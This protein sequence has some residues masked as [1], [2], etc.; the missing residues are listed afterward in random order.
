[1]PIQFRATFSVRSRSVTQLTTKRRGV[2]LLA[3][4]AFLAGAVFYLSDTA[5]LAAYAFTGFSWIRTE[6]IVTSPRTTSDP[7]IQFIARDQSP[8]LFREDYY[9]LCRRSLCWVR[10]FNPNQVVPVVYDPARPKR[11]YVGDW[12]LISGAITWF[13]MA[14]CVIFLGLMMCFAF[15]PVTKTRA[16]VS[17]Q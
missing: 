4:A 5:G 7:T 8:I 10:S 13:L 14:G 16:G 12:A 2:I 9:Q 1:M 11:A 6:G 15:I 17:V 3:G